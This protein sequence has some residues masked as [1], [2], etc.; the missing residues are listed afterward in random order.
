MKLHALRATVIYS[1]KACIIIH[2]SI[3]DFNDKCY[4]R[5]NYVNF[6]HLLISLHTYSSMPGPQEPMDCA[7]NCVKCTVVGR[8]RGRGPCINLPG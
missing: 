3:V 1:Q 4:F 8:L 6:R 5:N 7:S 2:I